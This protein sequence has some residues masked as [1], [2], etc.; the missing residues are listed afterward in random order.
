MRKSLLFTFL[1][2]MGYTAIAQTIDFPDVHFKNK[3]LNTYGTYLD[4]NNDGEIQVSEAEA[5]NGFLL[6]NENVMSP[7]QITDITGIEY[8]TNVTGFNLKNNQITFL[9]LSNNPGLVTVLVDNNDIT[10]INTSNNAA[11]EE[12]DCGKNLLTSIDVSGCPNL[13]RLDIRENQLTTI[14]VSQNLLL[15]ELL[16]S[17]NTITEI[18][19]TVNTMLTLLDCSANEIGILDVS[20][21]A[22]LEILNCSDCN[23]TSLDV[24]QC[25]AL[26][27]LACSLNHITSI[28]LENNNELTYIICA[29]NQLTEIDF[30][31]APNLFSLSCGINPLT[32]IDVTNNPQLKLLSC[33]ATNITSIDLSQ[34]INLDTL[35]LNSNHDLVYINLKNGSNEIMALNVCHF[36]WLYALET[37]CLDEVNSA[38]AKKIINEVEQEITVVADCPPAVSATD[39]FAAERFTLYPNPAES[40]FSINSLNAIESVIVYNLLGQKQPAVVTNGVVDINNL[41][42]GTYLIKVTDSQGKSSMQRILKK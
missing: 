5:Y 31:N 37:V 3:L 20:N 42:S 9:D 40:S 36:G 15:D 22:L 12:L 38:L 30:S 33:P 1:V 7:G 13:S 25:S 6:L 28:N 18:D 4:S 39:T 16:V 19:V 27:N 2:T 32:S 35:G 17:R 10:Y 29:Y 26:T 14:D 34:N 41:S 8:F 21:N 24:S 23:L 11:L